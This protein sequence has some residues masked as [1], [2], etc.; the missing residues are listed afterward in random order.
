[1][2]STVNAMKLVVLSKATGLS[3]GAVMTQSSLCLWVGLLLP[4]ISSDNFMDCF[5]EDNFKEYE[6]GI[7]SSLLRIQD[8]EGANGL[9]W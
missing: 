8:S 5:N 2:R 6:F 4:L 3:S 9:P 1:M 7:L